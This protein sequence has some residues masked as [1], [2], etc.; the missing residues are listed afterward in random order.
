MSIGMSIFFGN[1]QQVAALFVQGYTT[2]EIGLMIGM[3]QGHVSRSLSRLRVRLQSSG[4]PAGGLKPERGRPPKPDL[5]R[6][7]HQLSRSEM[8]E[9]SGFVEI[10]DPSPKTRD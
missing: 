3:R 2:V 10:Y 9:L 6:L 4:L 8:K 7:H 5:L 1:Q